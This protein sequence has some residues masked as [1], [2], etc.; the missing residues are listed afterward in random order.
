MAGSH[1]VAQARPRRPGGTVPGPAAMRAGDQDRA[2]AATEAEVKPH[3][4]IEDGSPWQAT[5]RAGLD[6][7]RAA[8]TM[9]STQPRQPE[10]V[11]PGRGLS[12]QRADG[13]GSA[14]PEAA[15]VR[16]SD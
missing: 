5:G 10:R 15:V 3:P 8:G 13:V 9:R 14:E 12:C 1:L 4:A 6:G 2:P 11:S 16:E 7:C